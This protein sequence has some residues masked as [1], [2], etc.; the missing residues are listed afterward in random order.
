[1]RRIPL[2][3][4]LGWAVGCGDSRPN[5]ASAMSDVVS[6]P[7]P[8]SANVWALEVV[9]CIGRGSPPYG[10]K[11][12][13]AVLPKDREPLAGYADLETHSIYLDP[14]VRLYGPADYRLIVRHELAHLA[15]GWKASHPGVPPLGIADHTEPRAIFNR[16]CGTSP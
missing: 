11:W 7:A 15:V 10:V 13:E 3:L 9:A 14:S 16:K 1:M 6:I 4:M 8:D 5:P 2:I 12:Y